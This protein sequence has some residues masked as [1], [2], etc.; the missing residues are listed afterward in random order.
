M[1]LLVCTLRRHAPNPHSCGNGGGSALADRLAAAMHEMAL[2]VAV[3]RVPCMS[4]CAQGPNVR[5]LPEGITWNRVDVQRIEEI[6]TFVK[7]HVQK[8]EES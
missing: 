8:R 1:K 3:E 4:L 5:L 2:D 6:L 7:N